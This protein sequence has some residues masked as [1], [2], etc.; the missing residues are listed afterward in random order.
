HVGHCTFTPVTEF[1]GWTVLDGKE[2]VVPP[3]GRAFVHDAGGETIVNAKLGLRV[4]FGD[5]ADLYT[6][7]GRPLT[8]DRWYENILRVEFRLFF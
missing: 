1:V 3:S 4:E 7:Y 6:G 8:G 2:S 5:R